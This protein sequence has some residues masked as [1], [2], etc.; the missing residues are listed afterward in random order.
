VEP[1][2]LAE[3]AALVR[4]QEAARQ[5]AERQIASIASLAVRDFSSWY[6]TSLITAWAKALVGRVEPVQRVLARSTDAYLARVAT[7]TTGRT[8]RPT[9]A[10]DVS[11]LR[12]DVTHAGAYGRVADTYRYQEFRLNQPD[13]RRLMSPQ[14]VALAR[15]ESVAKT[16]AMLVPRAQ[17]QKTFTRQ[18]KITGYRRIIHPELAKE[19]SC[20]LC[21]AASDRLY[22]P[23]ELMPIHDG[24]HCI[25]LPVYDGKDPGSTLNRQDFELLYGNAGGTAGEDLKRTKYKVVEHGELGPTLVR[26]DVTTRT[27]ADVKR[28]QREREEKRS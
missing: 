5:A 9:G 7:I 6:S 3:L 11:S 19:G 16:D 8:V 13:A 28:D 17:A 20:G 22:K 27:P 10:V 21:I 25:P 24:C 26:A 2:R 23:Q 14:Q 4:A 15:A 18:P 12:S 1:D